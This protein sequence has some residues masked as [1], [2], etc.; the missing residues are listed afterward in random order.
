[1]TGSANLPA[2]A[3]KSWFSP[4]GFAVIAAAVLIILI[5]SGLL[6]GIPR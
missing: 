6:P 3:R 4:N 5:V 2:Q 1:M